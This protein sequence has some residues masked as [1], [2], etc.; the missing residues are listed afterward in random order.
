MKHLPCHQFS[1]EVESYAYRLGEIL[2]CCTSSVIFEVVVAESL[3]KEKVEG[4]NSMVPLGA[5]VIDSI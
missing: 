2:R 1:I 4:A 5:I 3:R